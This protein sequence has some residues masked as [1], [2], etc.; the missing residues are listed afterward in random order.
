MDHQILFDY[1]ILNFNH[2][3]QLKMNTIQRFFTTCMMMLAFICCAYAQETGQEQ[4]DKALNWYADHAEGVITRFEGLRHD[5]S[6]L[7]QKFTVF[8]DNRAGKVGSALAVSTWNEQLIILYLPDGNSLKTS[9]IKKNDLPEEIFWHNIDDLG[10]YITPSSDITLSER[11]MPVRSVDKAKNVFKVNIDYEDGLNPKDYKQMIFKIHQNGVR[12]ISQDRNQMKD[13]EGNVFLDEMEYVYKL[14]TPLIVSKMFRGYEDGE[15]CPWVVKN[16]FF[17]HHKLLQYSRWKD[18]EP[19]KK[20]SQVVK[21]MI[22]SFYGGRPVKDTQWMATTENGERS[23]YCV[24]FEHQGADALA[25]VVC[26]NSEGVTSSWEFHGDVDPKTYQEGQSIWFVDDEGDFLPHMPEIH[27]IVETDK[28]LE[29]Y[30]RVYG[31]ESV[32]YFICREVGPVWLCLKNDYWIYV[33]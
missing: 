18:G 32:Q 27:C 17:N 28:G 29:F 6:Q 33:M 31:G 25:A 26:V 19:I 4:E 9:I 20:A 2:K 30:M 3:K 11:P 23:F 15:A 8:P 21:R 22:S 24:Q 10:L 12:L 16:S 14:N 1:S 5:K 7:P 13:E